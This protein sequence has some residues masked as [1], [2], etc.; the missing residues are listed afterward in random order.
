MKTKLYKNCYPG[1]AENELNF[2][3]IEIKGGL[4]TFVESYTEENYPIPEMGKF[5]YEEDNTYKKEFKKIKLNHK[6]TIYSNNDYDAKTLAGYIHLGLINKIK[7]DWF[8]KRTWIQDGENLKWLA[9]IP[10]SII[11]SIVTTLIIEKYK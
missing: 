8:F 9:S 2:I 4:A 1:A 5:S 6:I 10:V 7:L 3:P 11:T